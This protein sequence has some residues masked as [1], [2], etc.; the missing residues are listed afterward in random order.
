MKVVK[1]TEQV[2][3]SNSAV[4]VLA[5]FSKVIE[6]WNEINISDA[7]HKLMGVIKVT[8]VCISMF[9]WVDVRDA[10]APDYFSLSLSTFA[11]SGKFL[12]SLASA[13]EVLHIKL[14]NFKRKMFMYQRI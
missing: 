10:N 9:V 6:E 5:I 2:K 3:F 14:F 1:V 13:Q 8:D 4:D 11:G 7:D 12:T